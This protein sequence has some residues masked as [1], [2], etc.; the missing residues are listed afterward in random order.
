MP[1]VDIRQLPIPDWK[2]ECPQCDAPL[3]GATAHKCP[4]CNVAFDIADVIQPWHQ[5]RTPTFRGDE[6]PLP[7]FGWQCRSCEKPLAGAAGEQCPH[8]AEAFA[9]ES[10]VPQGAW[11]TLQETHT[12]GLAT[13]HV[14]RLLGREFI[15]Y[16]R[17][18]D[19]RAI[20]IYMG[21]SRTKILVPRE[22]FFD[23]THAL[24]AE[25]KRVAALGEA[26]KWNCAACGDANPA[27]FEI[28][29]KCGAERV[30][31]DE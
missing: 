29:W 8:C 24:A 15:P 14:A 22:F 20:D 5:L 4:A 9:R 16:Q 6:S 26:P 30:T 31:S 17:E 13:E 2:L 28:C 18:S 27:T 3:A 21:G 1:K 12:H 23:A 7:D 25:A 19:L 11:V 10:F